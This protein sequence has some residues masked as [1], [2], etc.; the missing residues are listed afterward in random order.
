MKPLWVCQNRH[1][2]GDKDRKEKFLQPLGRGVMGRLHQDVTAAR[3]SKNPPRLQGVDEVWTHV[4]IGAR[5][6]LEL[7][8]ATVQLMLQRVNGDSDRRAVIMVEAGEYMRC[9]GNY[10]DAILNKKSSHFNGHGQVRRTIV[11]AGEQVRMKV[12]HTLKHARHA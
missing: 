12:Y 1:V 10:T 5:H 7:N 3:E 6:Q 9:A 8:A 2:S 11:D 4:G